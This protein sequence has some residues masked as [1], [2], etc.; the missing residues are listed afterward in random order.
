MKQ[1]V[2]SKLCLKTLRKMPVNV[3]S[4]IRSKVEQFA[5]NPASQMANVKVL[6]GSSFIRLRVGEWRV[7]MD[8]N[9]VVLKILKI[10]SRG[11]IY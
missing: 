10:A 1:V 3:S 9:G 5:N 8:N 4:R 6:L 11:N 2:Y 7:I